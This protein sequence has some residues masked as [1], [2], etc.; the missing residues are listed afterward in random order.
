MK[1]PRHAFWP[2]DRVRTAGYSPESGERKRFRRK[3]A[4]P[5]RLGRDTRPGLH[6]KV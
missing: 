4:G 5:D 3:F 6:Y 2:G 1:S